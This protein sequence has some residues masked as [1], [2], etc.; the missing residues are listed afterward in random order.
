MSGDGVIALQPGQ[1]GDIPK[2]GKRHH[3][4]QYTIMVWEENGLGRW[5]SI[6]GMWGTRVEAQDVDTGR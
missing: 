4:Q 1:E 6:A 3:L 5:I 2:H